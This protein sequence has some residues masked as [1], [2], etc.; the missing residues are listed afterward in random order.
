M[1]HRHG[2]EREWRA[3]DRSGY[4]GHMFAVRLAAVCEIQILDFIVP[5]EI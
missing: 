4:R 3:D 1:R 2:T 5:D